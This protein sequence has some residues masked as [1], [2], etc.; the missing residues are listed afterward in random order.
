MLPLCVSVQ[1]NPATIFVDSSPFKGAII[2]T[3]ELYIKRW[4]WIGDPRY[5][6]YRH[7]VSYRNCILGAAAEHLSCMHGLCMLLHA[8]SYLQ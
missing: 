3:P 8:M 4:G 7:I 2:D 5:L 6:Q 1:V